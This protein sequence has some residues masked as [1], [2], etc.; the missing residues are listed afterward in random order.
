VGSTRS[1]SRPPE[2]L[3]T[4]NP[5]EYGRRVR[6]GL[7]RLFREGPR[8][9]A[10]HGLGRLIQNYQLNK[11]EFTPRRWSVDLDGIPIDRPLFLLGVPGGGGTIVARTIYR[12]PNAVYASGNSS[13]WAGRDEIQKCAHISDLPEPLVLRSAHF[14][15]LTDAVE[16]HPLYGT[17][18]SPLYAID[19]FLPRYRRGAE[20]ADPETATA[21]HRVI[22][23]V[24][25]AYAHDPGDARFVDMSQMFTVQ[26]PYLAALL[27]DCDPH[28]VLLTRNPYA[29]CERTVQKDLENMGGKVELSRAQKIRCAVEIFD[30][31]Y[32]L[33][34]AAQPDVPMLVQQYEDFVDSPESAIRRICHFAGL[35]FDPRQVPAEGQEFPMGSNSS[36]KWFPIERGVNEAYLEQIQPDLVGALNRRCGDLIEQ[37][38]YSRL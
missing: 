9:A 29:M 37:L 34:L 24:I 22:R 6:S 21:L 10:R 25:R 36:G 15:N 28:F 35:D 5:R 26:V 12:H 4:P 32:R 27:Q 18:R 2:D 11:Y 14:F 16:D 17:Q 1:Q 23:K 33:A 3:I 38:G 30:N 7:A 19:E 8:S 13:W 20:D 31:S